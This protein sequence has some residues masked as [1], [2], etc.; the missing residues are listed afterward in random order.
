MDGDG[1]DA[2]GPGRL[3]VIILTWLEIGKNNKKYPSAPCDSP[4]EKGGAPWHASRLT[5]G[6]RREMKV[7]NDVESF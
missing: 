4:A 3:M 2:M 1:V 5:R 6:L 7:C